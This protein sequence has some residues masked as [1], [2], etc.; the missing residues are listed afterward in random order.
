[1]PRLAGKMDLI[2]GRTTRLTLEPTRAGAYA[3]LCAEYCGDSHS[4][5]ELS[6][7]V[8]TREELAAWLAQQAQPA[9]AP[10]SALAVRGRE[11]L[12]ASGCG[13]CHSVRGTAADGVV[14]PDLTHVGSRLRI[15][16]GRLPNDERALHDWL[17]RT[18]ELKPGVTMPSFHILPQQE[19]QALAAYLGGLE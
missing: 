4:F 9:R 13:A 1:V 17:A 18:R 19:L 3:G 12:L 8:S 14:G 5:M 6:V 16:A 7:V 10:A 2:P 11:R 15:A